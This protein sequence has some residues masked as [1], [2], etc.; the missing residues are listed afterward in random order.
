MLR[1]RGDLMYMARSSPQDHCTLHPSDVHVLQSG[2]HPPAA[3]FRQPPSAA[4]SAGESLGDRCD[5][6]RMRSSPCVS[7]ATG[8]SSMR[9]HPPAATNPELTDVDGTRVRKQARPQRSSPPNTS[10]PSQTSSRR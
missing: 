10:L 3:D 2:K 9:R 4:F 8:S 1:Q 5:H 6:S 7:K